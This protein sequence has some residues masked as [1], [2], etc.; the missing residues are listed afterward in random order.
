M[1]RAARVRLFSRVSRNY[2]LSEVVPFPRA[3]HIYIIPRI[4][5]ALQ[6]FQ[7]I[8]NN[9]QI[10]TERGMIPT[11]RKRDIAT[12]SFD[13]T[14]ECIV[15]PQQKKKKL[16][17]TSHNKPSNVAMVLLVHFHALFV[18]EEEQKC[19]QEEAE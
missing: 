18:K 17:I 13:R 11:S 5:H 15:I 10:H 3:G 14:A 4:N 19:F 7:E 6:L 1:P 12:S 8:W 2:N 16:V 9:H